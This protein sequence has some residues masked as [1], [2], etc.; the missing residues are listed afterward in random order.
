MM[1]A[2]IIKLAERVERLEELLEPSS[3]AVDVAQRNTRVA[4]L[5]EE[6][7]KLANLGAQVRELRDRMVQLAD[8]LRLVGV[9]PCYSCGEWFR[10]ADR[11]AGFDLGGGAWFCVRHLAVPCRHASG[12]LVD[13][14]SEWLVEH[15]SQLPA[16][17]VADITAASP[18]IAEAVAV[19]VVARMEAV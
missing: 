17:V 10:S 9:V 12:P 18:A 8:G 5:E 15:R 3:H 19:L 4:R 16:G 11:S 1:D 6:V 14:V 2:M 7:A 13:R